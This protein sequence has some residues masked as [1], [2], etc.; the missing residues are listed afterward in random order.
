MNT[1]HFYHTRFIQA[2]DFYPELYFY[3]AAKISKFYT[4]FVVLNYIASR[5]V[6]VKWNVAAKNRSRTLI[7]C[8]VGIFI[9]DFFLFSLFLFFLTLHQDKS[10][11]YP[12]DFC[13]FF[14]FRFPPSFAM[15]Q[16][17]WNNKMRNVWWLFNSLS[18]RL[19]DSLL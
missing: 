10:S 2:Y 4:Y 18:V 15:D 13:A 14:R 16:W 12:L 11:L 9:F 7:S 8:I 3:I 6:F 5:L 19:Y 17:H 1:V